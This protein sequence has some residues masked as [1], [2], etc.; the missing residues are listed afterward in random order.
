MDFFKSVFSDDLEL[1]DSQ[2]TTSSSSNSQSED[3]KP[4]SPS[5]NQSTPHVASITNAW[6]FGSTLFKTIATKSESVIGTY[7]RDLEDFSS[8]LKKETLTIREAASRAVKDLPARLETGAAAAQESLESVGQAIDNI[9]STV[10]EIIVQGKNSILDNDSDT[11]LYDSD[12]N[13]V[14][15]GSN[16]K[17]YSRV[18]ATIRAIQCD[19]KTYCEEAEDLDDYNEW[20][21]E[22]KLEEQTGE[23]ED[24]IEENKVIGEIYNEVVP[25]QVDK[26][27]FW[28][29]YFYRV[30][31][32]KKAEEARAKLVK[33]A[34]SGE[35]EEELSWDVDDDE[36]GE[37]SGGS[38]LNIASERE[39]VEEDSLEKNI[40]KSAGETEEVGFFRGNEDK[41]GVSQSKGDCGVDEK[42]EL[43]AKLVEFELS[44]DKLGLKSEE[45]VSSEGKNDNSDFSVVSS[46]PSSHEEE[47]LGWDE[48]EDIG[49]GDESKVDVAARGSPN[50][51]DL[52]QRLSAADEEEDLTWDIEDDDEPV[53][54]R[55]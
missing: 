37:E 48:I 31:R 1:S 8:G 22:F 36:Y 45:K 32:V 12:K 43:E 24:L 26:E 51:A 11:E 19:L 2:N 17:P 41:G 4:S 33:R 54:T 13:D 3:P 23:I 21:M 5:S 42:E 18:D 10:S 25:S 52:R 15:L 20:K 39:I 14:N 50:R 40:W 9:G 28:G 44:D 30:Y 55:S 38:K 27:T 53:K 16:A 34:V 46:Q 7:R 29:R 49:S 47:D 35:E 6:T